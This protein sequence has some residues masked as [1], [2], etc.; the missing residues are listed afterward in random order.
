MGCGTEPRSHPSEARPNGAA[1]AA[2]LAAAAAGAPREAAFR[3]VAPVPAWA[4]KTRSGKSPTT[5]PEVIC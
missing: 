2:P 3:P 4:A 5:D 1:S